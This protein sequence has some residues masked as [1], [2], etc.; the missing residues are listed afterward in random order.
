L[1]QR[2]EQEAVPMM[3]VDDLG[4]EGR[5]RRAEE[6]LQALGILVNACLGEPLDLHVDDVDQMVQ[7]CRADRVRRDKKGL[8]VG[9][10]VEGTGNRW[11]RR[12]F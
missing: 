1:L 9:D 4:I 12:F 2:H 10:G 7:S 3:V 8:V 11:G 6:A 5:R